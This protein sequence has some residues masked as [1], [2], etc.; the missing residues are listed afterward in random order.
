[1]I[2]DG[3]ELELPEDIEGLLVINIPS[4]MGGVALWAHSSGSCMSAPPQPQSFSDGLVEVSAG[5]RS[6]W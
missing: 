2:C 3:K 1:M 5:S 6:F 4:Y